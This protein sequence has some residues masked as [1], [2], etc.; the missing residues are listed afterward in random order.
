MSVL[1]A[2]KHPRSPVLTNSEMTLFK[3]TI[4]T[5]AVITCCL[6]NAMPVNAEASRKELYMLVLAKTL[7]MPWV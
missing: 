1:L 3:T 2:S 5:A 4:A 7:A 6:G